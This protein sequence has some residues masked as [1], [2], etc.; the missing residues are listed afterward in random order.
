MADL[1]H[2]DAHA[3]R[4]RVVRRD[5]DRY[6]L[7]PHA[8]LGVT[9]Q[10]LGDVYHF[11]SGSG[12]DSERLFKQLATVAIAATG[13]I[14]GNREPWKVWLDELQARWGER[15]TGSVTHNRKRPIEALF[16][17]GPARRV[18]RKGR[19][20]TLDTASITIE[21]LFQRSSDLCTELLACVTAPAV[22]S[23]PAPAAAR[24][25]IPPK[26]PSSSEGRA[27]PPD[28]PRHP[29]VEID[30]FI[31]DLNQ[32]APNQA[33]RQQIRR[34]D[35]W[36]VAGYKDRT[37]FER[38]Q[39]GDFRNQTAVGKFRRVLAMQPADFIQALNAGRRP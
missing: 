30:T 13:R 9:W 27:T 35:I 32:A 20:F 28:P 16:A 14:I 5:F 36:T 10:E 29:R 24:T 33:G 1:Q 38:F 19:N 22:A 25:P 11:H 18:T 39:R 31:S 6:N 26:S 12:S 23:A 3:E 34:K 8:L 2:L 21:F 4:M 17:G 7:K 37:E 15:R